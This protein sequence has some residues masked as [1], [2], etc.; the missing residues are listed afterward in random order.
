MASWRDSTSA[1]AQRDLDGLLNVVL[2]FAQ[3]ELR[4]H[5]EFFPFGAAIRVDGKVEMIAARP[6]PDDEHPLASDVIA[7]CSETLTERRGAIRAGAVVVDV[8]TNEGVDA[9]RVDLEH[10]EGLALTVLLPYARKRLHRA[11][12]FGEIRAQAGQ[13]QIWT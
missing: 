12:E 10:A 5:G 2:A 1:Q 8:R 6:D 13:R 4:S 11:V 9:I 7:A 3:Q